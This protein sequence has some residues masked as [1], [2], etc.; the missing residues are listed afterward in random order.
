MSGPPTK[1][2]GW[3]KVTMAVIVVFMLVLIL[4]QEPPK[5]LKII[6]EPS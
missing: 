5:Y 3:V 1:A 2:G 4:F 6:S